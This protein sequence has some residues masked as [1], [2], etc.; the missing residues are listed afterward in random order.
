MDTSEN[1][2]DLQFEEATAIPDP[3]D[4]AGSVARESQS[5]RDGREDSRPTT[6]DH[7]FVQPEVGV[8]THANQV[9]RNTGD[10]AQEIAPAPSSQ[11]RVQG[12]H[13]ATNPRHVDGRAKAPKKKSKG[14]NKLPAPQNT[15]SKPPTLRLDSEISKPPGPARPPAIHAAKIVKVSGDL[16]DKGQQGGREIEASKATASTVPLEP[17][18]TLPKDSETPDQSFLG[19]N[20]KEDDGEKPKASVADVIKPS[21][22]KDGEVESETAPALGGSAVPAVPLEQ[23]KEPTS[24]A[25]RR[26]VS[27]STQGSTDTTQS[28]SSS[29]APPSS[30]QTER[31]NSITQERLSPMI[32]TACLSSEAALFSVFLEPGET[33]MGQEPEITTSLA[34]SETTCVEEQFKPAVNGEFGGFQSG[35]IEENPEQ[36]PSMLLMQPSPSKSD[37]A[38]LRSPARSRAPSIPPRSSSL[39]AP[40]TP[41][42]THQKKK[43]KPQNFTPVKQAPSE[44]DMCSPS[45]VIGLAIKGTKLD[46][47]VQT[48]ESTKLNFS[49]LTIDPAAHNRT[50]D[51]SRD[52]PKPETP[53]LMDDG[54]RVAPP[55]ISRQIEMEAT[56]ADQYYAQKDNYRAFHLGNAIQINAAFN[57]LD[58]SDSTSTRSC[59]TST[60]DLET[61]LRE[62]GFRSLSGTSP[63]TIKDP[64]LALLE[65]IDEGGNPLENR[66]HK[67]GPVLSWIDD[68]G[69]IGPGM[70]FSAWTKQHEMIEVVKKATAVKRLLASSPPLP[71]TR[72]ESLRQQL[73]RSITQ[74]FADAQEQQTTKAKA[75]KILRA[76]ALLD[77]IPQRDSSTSEMEKWARNASLFMEENVSE[78]L[79]AHA[80]SRKPTTNSLSKSSRGTLSRKHQQERRHPVFINQPEPQTLACK[81]GKDEDAFQTAHVELNNPL[82]SGQSTESE[83]SPST[84]GRRTPSEEPPALSVSVMPSAPLNQVNKLK[85]LCVEMGK[86]RRRWSDDR[87]RVSSPQK[88][89]RMTI[90]DPE[91]KP[92]DGEFDVRRVTDVKDGKPEPEVKETENEVQLKPH[93]DKQRENKGKK[94]GS[95]NGKQDQSE[96]AKSDETKDPATAESKER[97]PEK[98]EDH[99][100]QKQT[101]QPLGVSFSSFGSNYATGN[102]GD[103]EETQ[104]NR[105]RGGHSPLKR[106][107]YN[108]VAGRGIDGKRG[109]MKEGSKDPWALPQGEKPWVGG[110]GR[111][112]KK[113]RGRQ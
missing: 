50:T 56:N 13:Q 63:F 75:Q 83:P 78:P 3:H 66:T 107:G 88:E 101:S 87:Q 102:D 79:P 33:A 39:A 67:D 85:D 35:P 12:A 34:L 84:L 4:K 31:S 10:G 94:L 111:G 53:F 89:E 62:A 65:L 70:S 2:S 6:Q 5:S 61:T 38:L 71:W 42:K 82:T 30:S 52:L 47:S 104:H 112:G 92:S 40:S 60:S 27:N 32:Q 25:M 45:K 37:R 9:P 106:S 23:S 15:E 69:K 20:P 93:E 98:P 43:K 108:A 21:G 24:K 17:T 44:D 86:D 90:S 29:M 95:E 18:F 36:T 58:C 22:T 74:F 48:T 11:P 77:T 14:S 103:S 76:N 97:D 7:A 96:P 51:K 19:C 100:H 54:V 59:E 113:K 8:E 64:G 80:Q 109:G 16:E 1:K 46:S 91:L 72:I 68:K 55:K 49:I 41:I 105:R 28:M 26:D 57:T 81:L 73:L 110:E 99:T